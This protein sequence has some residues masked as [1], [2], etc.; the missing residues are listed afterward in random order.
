MVKVQN[1]DIYILVVD[2]TQ[3]NREVMARILARKKYQNKL[4][5]NGEQALAAVAERLPDLILLDISMPG[6]DGFE[7]C[8]RLKAD[9]RTRDIP[10]MFISAHDATEDKL[11]AFHVGGVDYITKPFKIEEVLARVETQVTLAIQRKSII[12]LSELKDQLLRTVSHDLKNP[13]HVIMGYSSLLMEDGYVTKPEDLR[14]MSKAIFNSAERMYQLV[15]NL[16]ELSQIED[17]TELQMLPLSLT[18]L[19]A[20][21]IPEFELNAQAKHQSFTFEAPPD[22]V[23]VN[24][25]TMRL[26]QVLSNLVSNAI[27]YTPENGH[28]LLTIQ[29][30]DKNVRLCVQDDGLGIPPEALPQ[31]FTKFFRVN[32][33]KHRSVEGTGLGLSIVKAIIEQHNGK[34]WV[35][36]ELGKGS[37]FIFSLPILIA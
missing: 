18:Q 21:M 3:T 13:L 8:E 9:E 32:T 15:T 34:I 26:G 5:E 2:D 17:G 4:V 35:E 29:K 6:M 33:T 36:S 14:N 16:L 25:D 22:D 30:E 31:L 1:T 27:K 19:C 12:E 10:V 24:G 37:K 23:N 11:R 20:D 7:V 28:V